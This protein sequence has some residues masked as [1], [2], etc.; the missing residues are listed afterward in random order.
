M[1][2]YNK[3]LMKTSFENM[4]NNKL[5]AY[6]IRHKLIQKGNIGKYTKHKILKR[7]Y[8]LHYNSICKIQNYYKTRVNNN[9]LY[10]GKLEDC[11]NHETIYGDSFKDINICYIYYYNNFVFDIR[12]LKMI[13]DGTCLNPYTQSKILVIDCRNINKRYFDLHKCGINMKIDNDIPENSRYTV[14]FGQL[15]SS[16]FEMYLYL[17]VTIFLKYSNKQYLYYIKYL[18]SY[19]SI[20]SVFPL[21][22]Y[23]DIIK[24]YNDKQFDDFKYK[25]VDLLEIILQTRDAL[26]YTR[27]N[28]IVDNIY[29]NIV[30]VYTDYLY[31]VDNYSYEL[32]S[33]TTFINIDND[34]NVPLINNP[35]PQITVNTSQ[36][37][38]SIPL[39][40]IN[41]SN[42]VINHQQ[43]P[44]NHIDDISGIIISN[45]NITI[46]NN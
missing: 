42:I 1:M 40:P 21:D 27:G 7:I 39:S 11:V 19:S 25:I 5:H 3:N 15:Q 13:I 8:K 29:R 20:S 16:L 44:I 28:I 46:N 6:A 33:N 17:N 24:L 38:I 22:T 36:I 23:N 34:Y 14:R 35:P 37:N 26:R 30:E 2:K 31:E 45:S 12:E 32:Y 43:L 9:K 41:N 10:R 4:N 18:R